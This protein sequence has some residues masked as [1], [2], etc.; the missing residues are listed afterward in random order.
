MSD[1]KPAA[2]RSADAASKAT[3]AYKDFS[4]ADVKCTW[5]LVQGKTTEKL[6][7]NPRKSWYVNLKEV[8]VNG[9]REVT[10]TLV[11]VV[12]DSGERKH[13]L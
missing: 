2:P 13:R 1:E 8:T 11:D 9:D 5:D 12:D 3:D 4:A 10:W 7:V 6:R